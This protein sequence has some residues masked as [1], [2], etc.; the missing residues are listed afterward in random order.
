MIT[1]ISR[2]S[3]YSMV[4]YRPR[5]YYITRAENKFA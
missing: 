3:G 1:R 4:Q 2:V 5:D